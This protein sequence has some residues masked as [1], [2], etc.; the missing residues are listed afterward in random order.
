MLEVR[1]VRDPEDIALIRALFLEYASALGIDLAFQNFD[2]ELAGLPGAYV[3]PRGHLLIAL[4]ETH[5]I[6]CVALRAIDR[7]TAEL[8]RLYVRP[9]GRGRGA[10]RRLVIGIIELAR[11]AGYR[12]IRL[13]SL[14]S[15][16]EAA[17]LYASLGFVV[18]PA[19]RHNPVAGTR[20]MELVLV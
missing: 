6:G 2:E 13:D 1:E 7:Q 5:P 9:E 18:I 11:T 16:I 20:F 10:G 3:P 15:M 12:K 14:P 8:K 19:Y 17:A 4:E